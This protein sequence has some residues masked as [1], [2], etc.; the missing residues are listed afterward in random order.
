MRL[1]LKIFGE[2]KKVE[3]ANEGVV[4]FVVAL[5]LSTNE[6]FKVTWSFIAVLT[7]SE[8]VFGY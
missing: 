4:G 2:I 7:E 5:M 6:A 8:Q 1:K 3:Y